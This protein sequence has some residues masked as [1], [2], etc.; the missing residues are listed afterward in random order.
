VEHT[1][2]KI[3]AFHAEN[4]KRLRV[5]DIQP[6]PANPV[7]LL[8]GKNRQGKT[9]VLESIWMTLA[10][11]KAI[12]GKPIREGEE[13]ASVSL[14]FGEFTV[15]R[16]FT[17]NNSYLEIKNKDGFKAP[18]PQQF[19]S[20]KLSTNARNPM[21]FMRLSASEQ[22]KVLQGL[23]DIALDV[24][25]FNAITGLKPTK[26]DG[27][28][29]EVL[30]Q[31]Y[32]YLYG[33][34]A[35]ANKEMKRLAGAV[36]TIQVPAD[37]SPVGVSVKE[38][39]EERKKLEADAQ[40]IRD[41]ELRVLECAKHIGEKGKALDAIDNAIIRLKTE[42]AELEAE[43]ETVES[44]KVSLEHSLDD[45]KSSPIPDHPDFTGIDAR[46]AAADETNRLAAKVQ[47]KNSLTMELLDVEKSATN[48]TE[49]L[50]AIKDYKG[51]LIE[52]AGLPVPGLG[53][54]N[55]EVTFNGLPLSQA[56][57]AEQI[58]VSCA[59]CMAGNPAIG[60]LT[61]D[62][63]WMELDQDSQAALRQWADQ[64]GA[65]IWVTK[66]QEE[67][68]EEGFFIVDGSVA[69]VNG[70]ACEALVTKGESLEVALEAKDE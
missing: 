26:L 66:V 55:G 39:F 13:S 53:F 21:E 7:V 31:A 18:S 38:L 43:R 2:N 51:R 63:G 12:P 19:L 70:L 28:P 11:E 41:H 59:V 61:I 24:E 27:D 32:Q 69:A 42:I 15:T 35:D 62:V 9:S 16:R 23:V 52:S 68:G 10:G 47:E 57:G 37:A 65:Q 60:V 22:V 48:L 33:K 17:V 49:R 34:R 36:R 5:V 45:L 58:T 40:I 67:P 46:I 1:P 8:T 6:N 30:D 54:E 44:T 3:L 20:S 64:V 56:S 29:I 25:E 4:T 50:V 14:D